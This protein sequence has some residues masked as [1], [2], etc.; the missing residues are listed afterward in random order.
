MVDDPPRV[1]I[2][3]VTNTTIYQTSG[4]CTPTESYFEAI[5]TDDREVRSATISWSSRSGD[6]SA[7]MV[8]D[9]GSWYGTVG[10]FSDV[11]GTRDVVD[12]TVSAQDSANQT[13]SASYTVTVV[14]GIYPDC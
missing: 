5:A 2:V 8:L 3:R 6:G 7:D 9:S 1:D 10:P 12:V 11:R 4:Q 14:Y 13:G